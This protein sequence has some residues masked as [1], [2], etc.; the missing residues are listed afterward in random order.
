MATKKVTRQLVDDHFTSLKRIILSLDLD[1]GLSEKT[2][3]RNSA[4]IEEKLGIELE[5]HPIK[6][7][8]SEYNYFDSMIR[9]DGK[10]FWYQRPGTQIDSPT[11]FVFDE[12]EKKW[13]TNEIALCFASFKYFYFRYFFIKDLANRVVRPDKLVAQM[14]FLDI[15]EDWNKDGL[16]I[17]FIIL[18]ARQLGMSTVVEAIL[19]WIALFQKGVHTVIASAE[20]DKSIQMSEMIW[21]ALEN[22]PLW[23][24][25]T[26]TRQD[27]TKGPEFHE[28]NSDILIQHGAKPK[29]IAR[30]STPVAAHL[31]ECAY[32]PT[33]EETIE[34]SIL[35][36]MHENARTFLVLESTA[37]AKGDWWHNRWLQER[38]GEG[39]GRNEFTPLFLP[40]YVG[41]DKYPTRDWIRNHPIPDNWSPLKETTKQSADAKLYVRTSKLLSKYLGDEWEMPREQMWHYEHRYRMAKR[42]DA[43]FKRFRAEFASDERTC[44]NSARTSVFTEET[45]DFLEKNLSKKYQDYAIVGDG[46]GRKFDLKDFYNSVRQPIDVNYITLQG[47]PR[48]WRLVSL[49]E[50]PRDANLQFYLRVWE[51]PRPDYEYT[52]AID[53]AAGVGQNNTDFEI[54]RK[55]KDKGDPDVQVAQLRSPFISCAEAPPFALCLGVFYGQHMQPINQAKMAPETQIAVGDLISS[56][57]SDDGY[58]N[59]HYMERY[60]MRKHP[61]TFSNRRGWATTA[62]SRPLIQQHL[63]HG[64]ETGWVVINSEATIDE[65]VNLES[66]ETDSGKTKYEHAEGKNDDSYLALAIAYF[67]S[68]DRETL[69]ERLKSDLRPN[70]PEVKEVKRAEPNSMEEMLAMRFQRED[71]EAYGESDEEYGEFVY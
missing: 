22:M 53:V 3:N 29:G 62:W 35:N 25:P 43:D 20:E 28:T 67:V 30:G 1:Y 16:P 71:Q 57:L 33:P 18:K 54:L 52:I 63:K 41:R 19:L 26:L 6:K 37:R 49:K 65:V 42:T 70:K 58:I 4:K 2:I 12:D 8:V 47:E 36:A 27:R 32:Y 64:I 66:E 50:T 59:F 39:E 48:H 60:D 40:W 7:C 51:L 9:T 56:Q 38:E 11:P 24:Q 69:T 44:F 45:I 15:V 13:I 68:H 61:G 55:G 14:V 17:K 23:L 34:A 10:N 21:I 31:S 5:A 46:I